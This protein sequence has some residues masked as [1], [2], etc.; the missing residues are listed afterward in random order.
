MIV[1]HTVGLNV[2][3]S[4]TLV[5]HNLTNSFDHKRSRITIEISISVE[6]F[7]TCDEKIDLL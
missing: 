3:I 2:P 5:T 4:H 6:W 7:N 1:L